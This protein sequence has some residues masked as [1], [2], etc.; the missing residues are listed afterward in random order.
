[1]K[2]FH[3][4][5]SLLDIGIYESRDLASQE[6]VFAQHCTFVVVHATIGLVHISVCITVQN[7]LTQ[8]SMEQFPFS[9]QTTT[10]AQ[11]LCIKVEGYFVN[12][13]YLQATPKQSSSS[14]E[15]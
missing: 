15:V 12:Y 11:M 4:D 8:Q 13:N 10:V 5:P 2:N 14:N 3:N 9:L 1:M 7:C 6:T